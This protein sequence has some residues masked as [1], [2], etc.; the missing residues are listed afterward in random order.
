MEILEAFHCKNP[1]ESY[2]KRYF[3]TLDTV[4]K[5]KSQHLVK[6]SYYGVIK[7]YIVISRPMYSKTVAD[8]EKIKQKKENE[9][10]RIY[11]QICACISEMHCL[12]SSEV[13]SSPS[14][15]QN[16]KQF[17]SFSKPY[18]KSTSLDIDTKCGEISLSDICV[19][20]DGNNR[21]IFLI[22]N[23]SKYLLYKAVQLP[24]P[25][26]KDNINTLSVNFINKINDRSFNMDSS[27][28]K[29]DDIWSVGCILYKLLLDKYPFEGNNR[30]DKDNQY[31][32]NVKNNIIHNNITDYNKNLNHKYKN[33]IKKTITTDEK[34]I[35]N[36][37]SLR[38]EVCKIINELEKPSIPKPPVIEEP[39]MLPTTA[40]DKV[41]LRIEEALQNS[42]KGK[43]DLTNCKFSDNHIKRFVD[44]FCQGLRNKDLNK[45]KSEVINTENVNTLNLEGNIITSVGISNLVTIFKYMPNLIALNLNSNNFGNKGVKILADNLVNL[46]NL[47]YLDVARI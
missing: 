19:S 41:L 40:S 8:S 26:N 1:L 43:I 7:D 20:N 46:P 35:M 12:Q 33:I 27:L 21:Q 38:N 34:N 47:K 2:L 25:I 45:V 5:S 24:F 11:N 3:N 36:I 15:I 32:N 23:Y 4:N 6:Y 39:Y 13:Q 31:V 30:C 16:I 42:N 17:N 9:K 22:D 44:Y 18:E 29:N 10:M 37:N 28:S 14:N